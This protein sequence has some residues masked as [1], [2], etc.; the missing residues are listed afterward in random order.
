M[1]FRTHEDSME[2]ELQHNMITAML[3]VLEAIVAK[4]DA[5]A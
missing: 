3:G 2:R 4:V 1:L 5:A